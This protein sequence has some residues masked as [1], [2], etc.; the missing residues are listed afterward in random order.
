MTLL[1]LALAVAGLATLLAAFGHLSLWSNAPVDP[2][3]EAVLRRA[4]RGA[5]FVIALKCLVPQV[6]LASILVNGIERVRGPLRT[7]GWKEPLVLWGAAAVAYAVVGPLLLNRPVAGLPAMQH[8]NVLQ[9]LGTGLA[10]STGSGAAL[11]LSAAIFRRLEPASD[12]Q[13]RGASAPGRR[14][15]APDQIG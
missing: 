10:T 2:Q 11:W 15:S 6:V 3:Q 7:L 14:D 8:A 5:F 13:V 9:H 1:A 12:A 4:L